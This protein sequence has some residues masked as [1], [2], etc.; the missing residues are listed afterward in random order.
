MVFT[1]P[2]TGAVLDTLKAKGDLL[3]GLTMSGKTARWDKWHVIWRAQAEMDENVASGM[4]MKFNPRSV[5]HVNHL[6]MSE[7]CGVCGTRNAWAI[8]IQCDRCRRWTHSKC[9]D[10]KRGPVQLAPGSGAK[11]GND[12]KKFVCKVCRG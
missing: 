9:T 7:V 11:I 12:G 6:L 5:D 3:K 1:H 8:N 4:P 2:D 10:G